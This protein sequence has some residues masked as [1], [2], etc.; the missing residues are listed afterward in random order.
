[1]RSLKERRVLARIEDALRRS[2][3]DLSARLD[4]FDTQAAG[5]AM[6]Y[7]E[8][9]VRRFLVRPMAAVALIIGITLI[10]AAGFALA[11]SSTCLSVSY[12]PAAPAGAWRAATARQ[13]RL[14]VCQAQ[15]S[16]PA[17]PGTSR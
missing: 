13:I 6:P 16:A 3:A 5:E 10:T 8:H 11:R 15:P 7:A 9:L 4:W 14:P 1:M 12:H 17:R 2:D